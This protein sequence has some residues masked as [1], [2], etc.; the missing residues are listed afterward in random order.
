MANAVEYQFRHSPFG[1]ASL[2]KPKEMAA[3]VKGDTEKL[4]QAILGT[5]ILMGA[6]EAKR[7]GF[8][9][10]KWYE[11]KTEDG[12]RIDAR[13]YFPL[14]PYLLVADLVVRAEDGRIPPDAKDILQ[15]LTGAQFR[16]GAGLALVDDFVN[17]LAGVDSEE[18]LG[19]KVTRF[20]S[21]VLGGYLTPLRMFGDFLNQQQTF[22]TPLPESTRFKSS[23]QL[24]KEK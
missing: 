8:G 12:K 18:K 4:S 5:S 10:E 14:T 20:V 13:P 6:I 22:R 21:D 23:P 3:I 2:L 7:R 24:S 16:T 1:F 15:G 9:G 17:D 11:L 19:R